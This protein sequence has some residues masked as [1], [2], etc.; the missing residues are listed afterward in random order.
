MRIILIGNYS[1]DKQESMQRF[2]EM[3]NRGILNAGYKAEIWKPDIIVGALTDKTTGG[4]AK[5]LGYIDK[6][7]IFPLVLMWRLR[8][9]KLK[10]ASTRFHVCDHSNS[11]YLKFLPKDRTGITC[12]DVLAIRGA[13]GYQDAYCEASI[14]GK[15]LQRWILRNLTKSR[16]LA[17]ASR[18]TLSQLE[19]LSSH[20][21]AKKDWRVIHLGF[22]AKFAPLEIEQRLPLLVKANV[23]TDVP[24]ILHVGSDQPR[25]NRKMLMDMVAELGTQWTG[26]IYYAGQGI[27]D[28]IRSHAKALGLGE[29]VF[30][31]VN[32]D[33][34]T[35][36]ALYSACEAFVFPS[37][38]EGFGWPLIEAQACG[39]PVIASMIEP[40]PEVS[41]GT[42]LHA[43]PTKPK[44]FAAAFLKL[45]D[46][47]FRANVIRN[48][49]ANA[50]E[51]S[52]DRMINS[53]LALHGLMP[54]NS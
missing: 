11:P 12:H 26:N 43:D 50:S 8:D 34:Q 44:E 51:Y 18:L 38:S 23:K 47:N 17:A 48:G 30:S 49:F 54:N 1:H 7:I 46:Q 22:N 16:L 45:K 35:L 13:M 37:F 15:I 14:T 25:K 31:V 4:I 21:D 3:L 33:H 24:F 28:D 9:K 52:V 2:A 10:K 40:M 42:A 20:Q 29:R 6:Y 32:P 19:N 39:A 36:L 5:W 53:Y 27:G 41:N